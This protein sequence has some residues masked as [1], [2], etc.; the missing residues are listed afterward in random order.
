M[1]AELCALHTRVVIKQTGFRMQIDRGVGCAHQFGY[2]VDVIE[3][4]VCK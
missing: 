3:M 1:H 4:R 2:A